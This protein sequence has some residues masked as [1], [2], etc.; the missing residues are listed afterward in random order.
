MNGMERRPVV[1][2]ALCVIAG[3][4]TGFN[5]NAPLAL[6]TSCM[7]VLMV[8]SS[9]AILAGSARSRQSNAWTIGTL[10]VLTSSFVAAWLCASL[11]S[12]SVP[13]PHI[14]TFLARGRARVE[15]LADIADTPV[16]SPR[17]SRGTSW[18]FPVKILA[19]RDKEQAVGWQPSHGTAYVSW[20][21]SPAAEL[22]EYGQRWI[23]A[24]YAALPGRQG[25]GRRRDNPNV[26]LSTSRKSS[27]LVTAECGNALVKKCLE[28]RSYA[29]RILSHGIEDFPEQVGIMNSLIL[30]YRS[31]VSREAYQDFARTGTLHIFAISGSHVVVL[32]G[33]IIFVL[34]MLKIQRTHWIIALAPLLTYYTVMTGLQPSAVR[35]CIMAV[36]Y[37]LAPLLKRKSDI[38]ASIAVAAILII[39]VSPSDICD[40]GCLLSFIAV[41]GI[42]LLYPLIFDVFRNSFRADPLAPQPE[43]G[44][45]PL[46]RRVWLEV[47]MLVSTSTAA[48]L[49]TLPLTAYYFGLFSPIALLGNLI[50]I[51]LSSLIIATGCLSIFFGSCSLLLA[52]IFNHANL[53]FT[54]LLTYV[55]RKFAALPG[56]WMEVQPP[57]LWIVVAFYA[58]LA[59]LVYRRSTSRQEEVEAPAV[60]H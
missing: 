30:G 47:G 40:V 37:W 36:V 41:L 38:Y 44:A 4:W 49:V 22:P 13:F 6:L 60:N 58:M 43:T 48:W 32:A 14:S 56:G 10:L 54:A 31:Q 45:A 29:S 26:F 59:L 55:M 46:L 19:I 3:T 52:D 53:A 9:A 35:A 24:G 42:V 2:V 39:A 15:V 16:P 12:A 20:Y 18:R 28:Q 7:V 25:V 21:A 5:V 17:A 51:P 8:L 57:S 50:A 1:G 34:G 33:I 11:D 23:L 27:T